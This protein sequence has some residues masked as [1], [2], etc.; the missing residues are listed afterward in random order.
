MQKKEDNGMRYAAG[1][2]L[3]TIA[4]MILAVPVW[5]VDRDLWA[6]TLFSGPLSESSLG[7]TITGQATWPGAVVA[8]IAV[9]RK[10]D[11]VKSGFGPLKEWLD[12]EL[13]AQAVKHFGR[14]NH[15]EL[16]GLFILRWL[17]FPWDAHMDTSLAL[18]EGISHAL[19]VPDVEAIG[20]PDTPKTLN[21][22][23]FELTFSPP[24]SPDMAFVLRLH[25]RSGLFGLF[26]GKRDASNAIVAGVRFAF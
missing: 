23:L 20:R 8:G 18:G 7:D 25:H 19:D 10:F 9:S 16:N 22:L 4:T 2:V 17:P 12:F 6:T 13:E 24:E 3:V 14:Q 26:D 21:Y 11:A 15:W 5:A 1:V